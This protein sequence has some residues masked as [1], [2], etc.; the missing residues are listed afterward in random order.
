MCTTLLASSS[1][2]PAPAHAGRSTGD[3]TRRLPA[4][5][6]NLAVQILPRTAHGYT[7]PKEPQAK[8]KNAPAHAGRS[9]GDA[10]SRLPAPVLNLA[11]QIL[12]RTAHGYTHKGQAPKQNAP[13]HAGRSTGDAT[14]RRPAALSGAERGRSGVASGF[15]GS[16]GRG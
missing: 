3:A 1:N 16:G 7:P 4:P 2:P 15:A 11:V 14:R 13:A 10:T 6:L 9:T 5:A 12:P 8:K